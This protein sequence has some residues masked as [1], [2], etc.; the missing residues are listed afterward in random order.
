MADEDKGSPGRGGSPAGFIN[1]TIVSDLHKDAIDSQA[2]TPPPSVYTPIQA[3]SSLLVIRD[4][5]RS[6]LEARDIQARALD[7]TERAMCGL[8]M[9]AEG[10]VIPYFDIS[11]SPLPFYRTRILNADYATNGIR[12]KQPRKTPNHIYFPRAF[13]QTLHRYI[14][15]HN[16]SRVLIITEGEKKAACATK[17]GF[18]SIALSGVDSWRSRTILL[19]E[20]TEFYSTTQVDGGREDGR[21]RGR[22]RPPGQSGP[23]KARLPSSDTSVPELVTLAQ[24]FGDVI[25]TITQF[26]LYP[27]II[28]DSDRAG[29][30][31]AEVQR[32]AT[33][34]G[35]EFVYLGIH[36]NRVKQLIL[37]SLKSSQHDIVNANANRGIQDE[38]A[39][40]ESK[41]GLDD[42]LMQHGP[43]ELQRRIDLILNDPTAFPRHPNPKGFISTQLQNRMSRKSMQQ[44]ASMILTELDASGMRLRDKATQLPYYYDRQTA[45]L[46]P[47]QLSTKLPFHELAFGT[48]LYQRYGVS[49]ND[50]KVLIWLA[51]QFTGEEP[52]EDITPHRV[53]TLITERED[54][55]PN[56]QGVALQVSDSQFLAV[57]GSRDPGD[58]L[59]VHTNGGLGLLF[60]RDQVEPLD[61]DQVLEHFDHQLSE[62]REAGYL[63]PWWIEVLNETTIGLHMEHDLND[64]PDD[65][66]LISPH[67]QKKFILT[68][69]GRVMRTYASLLFYIS[70][71][72]LRHRGLQLPI[73]LTIG[74]PGSGKSSLY[75]LRLQ[76][77]TGRPLLRNIPTDIR[78]W[79]AGLAHVGGLHVTDNVHFLNKELK[80]RISDELAQPLDSLVL[81]DKGY[82]RMEDIQIGDKVITPLGG[83]SRV[84]AIHPR[85]LREVYKVEFLD[86]TSTECCADHLWMRKAYHQYQYGSPGSV[87]SLR[88]IMSAPLK[89]NH[90]G[91]YKNY[92]PTIQVG[93]D[94]TPEGGEDISLL[95]HP[96]LLG[97]LIGDGCLTMN[98]PDFG[99]SEEFMVEKVRGLLPEGNHLRNR[100]GLSYAIG[101]PTNPTRDALQA[102]GLWGH[103][104]Y[105]KFIPE[106]YKW[107][108]AENRLML[109][110]GLMDTDGTVNNTKTAIYN[111]ISPQLADDVKFIVQSLGGT[112]SNCVSAAGAYS[113]VM[114]LP[115]GI[116]PFTLPSKLE[117]YLSAN[118]RQ[119]EETYA[120]DKG[121]LRGM[122]SITP[123]GIKEV[124]CITIEDKEGLYITNDFIVTHNC[125]ITTEPTPHIEQRKLYTNSD[126]LRFPI[127]CVFGFTSIQ[128]PF[129][130]EDLI[131]RSVIFHT[132]YVEREP[133]GDWVDKQI[134]SR[135][136]RE[137]WIAHHLVFLHLFLQ[138]PWDEDFRTSHRLSHLEQTLFIASKVTTD[139]IPTLSRAQFEAI[140]S[141]PSKY[142]HAIQT[143]SSSPT[144]PPFEFKIGQTM[145]KNQAMQIESSDWVLQGIKAWLNEVHPDQSKP[146]KRFFASDISDWC[147]EQEEYS[148]N[149][150]LTNVRRLGRYMSERASTLASSMFIFYM[151]IQTNRNWY[152]YLPPQRD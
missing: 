100:Q 10:Y 52:I 51:S 63:K 149:E 133:E 131:Q 99:N 144:P 111:T 57:T 35:Y 123:A 58:A 86:G 74:P 105:T 65:E 71:F 34:L 148:D 91:N 138:Q 150:I 18:P 72:L 3:E 4:L 97:A 107:T 7:L 141:Q 15:I 93:V 25:D 145:L 88:E 103:K 46:I 142:H 135:G 152:R 118:K 45:H 23:I 79:Q 109:L 87:K 6:G 22:G 122:W 56:C 143:Q 119:R 85:G 32:A 8:P 11:G 130:N 90:A 83:K 121:V 94:L 114:R 146:S 120:L 76:I 5:K 43:E 98:Q 129:H 112:A 38:D 12:Y 49:A 17:L 37:P 53:H 89:N 60:E 30:L 80:Q 115:R 24:G 137:A 9:R 54:A 2:P 104:A 69:Q 26:N 102:L 19:P 96:Y 140:E 31:K 39:E 42:F 106:E 117:K 1:R 20:D 81:T 36:A 147:T 95:L 50:A 47:V 21:Q 70:P 127:S 59:R 27:I 75:A 124:Q 110:Q 126:V 128:P 108:S 116:E 134:A 61:V 82:K 77:S 64:E 136:G 78:D 33:M 13:R 101:G 92:I 40:S 125:R 44:V 84:V 14:Q 68:D 132:E 113:V 29:T 16:S 73:E 139:P 67:L 151:G 41:T 48:L 62:A 66:G 28:F 55:R